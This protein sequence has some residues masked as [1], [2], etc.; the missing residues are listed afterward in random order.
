MRSITLVIAAVAFL[1]AG[2]LALNSHAALPI[3]GVTLATISSSVIKTAPRGEIQCFSTKNHQRI[4]CPSRLFECPCPDDKCTCHIEDPKFKGVRV[5]CCMGHCK[6][7][8]L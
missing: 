1:L 5:I 3:G 6:C 2:M 7:E 8:P 4:A